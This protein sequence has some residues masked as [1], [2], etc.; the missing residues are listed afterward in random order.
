MNQGRRKAVVRW[1]GAMLIAMAS[2]QSQAKGR[3]GSKR[4]GGRGSSGKGSRYKGGR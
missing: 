1:V 2:S 3:T 4:S